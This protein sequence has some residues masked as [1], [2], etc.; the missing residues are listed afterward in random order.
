MKKHIIHYH[1]HH[2]A[3]RSFQLNCEEAGLKY[4]RRG[5]VEIKMK[6]CV[7]SKGLQEYIDNQQCIKKNF[8]R[9]DVIEIHRRDEVP[10]EKILNINWHEVFDFFILNETFNSYDKVTILRNP[11]EFLLKTIIRWRRGTLKYSLMDIIE[12][13]DKETVFDLTDVFNNNSV[14]KPWMGICYALP[15]VYKHKERFTLIE[16]MHDGVK[17]ILD[18]YKI[19]YENIQ[20]YTDHWKPQT[21][22]YLNRYNEEEVL[23]NIP[24]IENLKILEEMYHE[25]VGK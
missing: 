10:I 11:R 20:H 9:A 15:K 21:I 16:D 13:T 14:Y 6:K 18:Y 7:K 23:S 5:T 12:G 8:D 19:H 24:G 2:C 3:G 1:I 25:L 17:N 4:Y 22:V